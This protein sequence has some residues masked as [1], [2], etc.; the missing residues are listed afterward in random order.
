MKYCTATQLL[1]FSRKQMLEPRVMDLNATVTESLRMIQPLIGENI[2]LCVALATPLSC[3][4][5]DPGQIT[6]VLLNLCVNARD[7]LP[8]GG[9]IRIETLGAEVD[10]PMA[11]LHRGLAPGSYVKLVVA[12]TGAGMTKQVQERIFEPFFTTK[13][14]GK[15][16]G[17]GLS[18]VNGIVKQSGGYI[19][20]SSEPGQGTRFELYFPQTAKPVPA[21]PQQVAKLEA[22]GET[23][24]LAEDEDGL[25]DAIRERLEQCGYKVLAAANGEEALK[26]AELHT[27]PIDLLLTD[28]VMPRMGGLELC[29]RLSHTDRGPNLVTVY[30]SGYTDLGV[31][32]QGRL[33]GAKLLIHKPIP[34]ATLAQKLQEVLSGESA[35]PPS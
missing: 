13:E 22:R 17:L 35:E 28:V 20:V 23:V 6:Q 21:D 33:H 34:L 7:A 24:L 5:A 12:D 2:E 27:G 16:T 4:E 18:N 3:I 1:A 26:I 10:A 29:E 11:A 19:A 25:R 9:T 14:N 15:G 8:E 30:M 31:A 32:E